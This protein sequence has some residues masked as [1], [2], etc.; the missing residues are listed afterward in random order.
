ML[1][2][3]SRTLALRRIIRQRYRPL[4]RG[5]PDPERSLPLSVTQTGMATESYIDSGNAKPLNRAMIGWFLDKTLNSAADKTD[6]RLDLICAH[7]PLSN[8]RRR[9][10]SSDKVLNGDFS[11]RRRATAGQLKEWHL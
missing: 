7:S 6:P 3:Q 9:L 11:P 4:L 8:S 1:T 2:S 10:K 5:S